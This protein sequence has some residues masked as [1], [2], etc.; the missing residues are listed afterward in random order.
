MESL[1]RMNLDNEASSKTALHAT[2]FYS[3]ASTNLAIL[4]HLRRHMRRRAHRQGWVL[5]QAVQAP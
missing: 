4:Q 3:Y 2:A 5:Y 1:K